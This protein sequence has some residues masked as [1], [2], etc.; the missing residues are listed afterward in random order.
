MLHPDNQP[1]ITVPPWKRGPKR[2]RIG[3]SKQSEGKGETSIG[4]SEK[5]EWDFQ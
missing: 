4:T 1:R 3:I 2:L 5:K